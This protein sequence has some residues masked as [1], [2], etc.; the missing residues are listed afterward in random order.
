MEVIIVE[1][2][3]RLFKAFIA[4]IKGVLAILAGAGITLPEIDLGGI[5]GGDD[6]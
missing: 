3:V 2:L 1:K 5:L 4:F 6:K